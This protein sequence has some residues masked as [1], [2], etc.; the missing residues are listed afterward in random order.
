MQQLLHQRP[1]RQQ[2]VVS[3]RR[4]MDELLALGV[5]TEFM[6]QLVPSPVLRVATFGRRGCNIP[7]LLV[8]AVVRQRQG[9]QDRSIPEATLAVVVLE[10]RREPDF[11]EQQVQH[12]IPMLQVPLTLV[13]HRIITVRPA[14]AIAIRQ[15]TPRTLQLTT[16]QRLAPV[17]AAYSARGAQVHPSTVTEHTAECHQMLPT[18]P[19]PIHSS[20]PPCR[21]APYIRLMHRL[22]PTPIIDPCTRLIDNKWI[23]V[24]VNNTIIAYMPKHTKHTWL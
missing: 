19:R 17:E 22:L 21:L 8:E 20:R 12:T 4:P 13:N 23:D 15:A 7:R 18:S 9:G 11:P 5:F 6:E 16:R 3:R 10:V 24:Y 2:W 14:T 1:L